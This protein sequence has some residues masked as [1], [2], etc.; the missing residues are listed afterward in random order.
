MTKKPNNKYRTKQQKT[1]KWLDMQ[2]YTVEKQVIKERLKPNFTMI[3][4]S[5]HQAIIKALKMMIFHHKIMTKVI[6]RVHKYNLWQLLPSNLVITFMLKH[7]K[8]LKIDR[9]ELKKWR[10]L[11]STSKK[12]KNRLRLSKSNNHFKAGSKLIKALNN[13]KLHEASFLKMT[14]LRGSKVRILFQVKKVR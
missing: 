13:L 10:I 12:W 8:V 1:K 4:S 7:I 14:H 11:K 5:P 6:P 3:Y 9:M 2:K